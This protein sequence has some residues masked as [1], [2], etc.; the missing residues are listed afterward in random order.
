MNIKNSLQETAE[1]ESEFVII[2][3]H[4][5][6]NLL[7]PLGNDEFGEQFEFQFI[8]NPRLVRLL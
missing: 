8:E 7:P 5:M 2:C 6:S 3:S 4:Q 1:N